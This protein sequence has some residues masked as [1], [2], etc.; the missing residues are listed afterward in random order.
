MDDALPA[1]GRA[2]SALHRT[3]SVRSAAPPRGALPAPRWPCLARAT[4]RN[5]AWRGP[6][7]WGRGVP[8]ARHKIGQFRHSP[9]HY[10]I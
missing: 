6:A 1:K 2:R 8:L 3:G 5:S 4:I 7:A 10:S 9:H